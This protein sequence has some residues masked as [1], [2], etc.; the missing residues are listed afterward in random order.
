MIQSVLTSC[1]LVGVGGAL[2]ALARFGLHAW[3][4]TADAFPLGTLSAN[5]LGCFVI[6][7]IAY[8]LSSAESLHESFLLPEH[9]RLLFAV[10]F[11][12]GFTTLS[13]FVLE[14]TAMLHRNEVVTPFLYFTGTLAGGFGCFYAGLALT[15]AL[16][17][18]LTRG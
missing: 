14:V 10:G 12:G 3:L 4:Q 2:G 18:L 17:G 11:C 5:L 16:V 13:T 8:F 1:A 9:Y 7:V 6:G 15:R